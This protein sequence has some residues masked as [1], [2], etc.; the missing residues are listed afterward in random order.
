MLDH[1][2]GGELIFKVVGPLPPY[3]FSTVEVAPDPARKM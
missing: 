2:F 1:E 3:S